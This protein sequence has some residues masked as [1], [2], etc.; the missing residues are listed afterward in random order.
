MIAMMAIW[1]S[2]TPMPPIMTLPSSSGGTCLERGPQINWAPFSISEPAASVVMTTTR[3]RFERPI[4]GRTTVACSSQPTPAIS[5]TA[6]GK[7]T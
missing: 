1:C 7:A 4:S 2:E 5:A 3:T 6:P